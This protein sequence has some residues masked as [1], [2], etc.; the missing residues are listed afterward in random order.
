MVCTTLVLVACHEK[1]IVDEP[2]LNAQKY[3]TEYQDP[4]TM[5]ALTQVAVKSS[6]KVEQESQKSILDGQTK[7]FIGRYIT[8]LDCTDTYFACSNGQADLVLTLLEDGT[9][10]RAIINLGNLTFSNNLQYS[11]DA[12]SY[13]AEQHQIKLH[14]ENG[15][16]FFYDIDEQYNLTM[17]LDKIATATQVNRDYFASGNPLPK[18]RYV[19]KRDS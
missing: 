15:V 6:V 18:K 12:W 3:G 4:H 16:T 8:T 7:Q 11:Q 19:L 5:T 9:T 17:D 1:P 14:R 13:D 2:L 10:R